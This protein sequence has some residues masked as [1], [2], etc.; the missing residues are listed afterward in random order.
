MFDVG[1]RIPGEFGIGIDPRVMSSGVSTLRV[2]SLI[3]A[4]AL[5][6]AL[7]ASKFP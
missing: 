2:V 7:A 1:S 4:P 5:I 6:K 3:L